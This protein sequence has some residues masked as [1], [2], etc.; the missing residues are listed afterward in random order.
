[1]INLIKK[2]HLHP[3]GLDLY[4]LGGWDN[5]VKGFKKLDGEE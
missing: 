3:L 1:M 4:Y 5:F 2:Y